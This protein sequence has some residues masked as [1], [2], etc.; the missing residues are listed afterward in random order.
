MSRHRNALAGAALGGVGGAL[1]G[2]AVTRNG[3]G[4]LIG[5]ALGAA[6]G[7]LIGNSMDNNHRR[8]SY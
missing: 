6:T 8:D 5:G 3:K 2:G 7:G 1:V 4:A